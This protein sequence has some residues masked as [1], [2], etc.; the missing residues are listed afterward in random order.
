M[1]SDFNTLVTW[2]GH[3][4]WQGLGIVTVFGI[5]WYLFNASIALFWGMLLLLV[6]ARQ[7]ARLVFVIALLV[8]LATPLLYFIDRP[9][10]AQRAGILTFALLG[11]GILVNTVD[12]WR[13][14]H[15]PKN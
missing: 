1:R 7:S 14:R 13:N 4:P 2:L 9:A 10:Q 15:E 12:T 5:I 8:V 3:H 11:L 6:V